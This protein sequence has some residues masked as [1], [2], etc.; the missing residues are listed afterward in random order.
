MTHDY[1]L[2]AEL[3]GTCPELNT[4]KGELQYQLYK[5]TLIFEQLANQLSKILLPIVKE[6]TNS[7]LKFAYT[8]AKERYPRIA[9]LAVYSKKARI[10]KKNKARLMRLMQTELKER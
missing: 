7:T 5:A 8:Y 4:P 10:R 2:S 3:E 9:H 6:F 1:E